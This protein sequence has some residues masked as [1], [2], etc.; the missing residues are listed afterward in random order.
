M[1]QE[2]SIGSDQR[3][4]AMIAKKL[5]VI[6]IFLFPPFTSAS[7]LCIL[8][9]Y[10]EKT[11][12]YADFLASMKE[13]QLDSKENKL[14]LLPS[15]SLSTGQYVSNDVKPE[16][17]EYS[18]V[19]LTISQEI[20]GGGKYAI[21]NRRLELNE[22]DIKLSVQESR[23]EY[24]MSLASDISQLNYLSDQLKLN[25]QRLKNQ[26]AYISGLTTKLKLGEVALIE[27][28]TAKSNYSQ[29]KKDKQYI[30][31]KIELLKWSISRGFKIPLDKISA[32]S[33]E[34]IGVC[35]KLSANDIIRKKAELQFHAEKTS[36]DIDKSSLSPSVTASLTFSPK[37]DSSVHNISL[38]RGEYGAYLGIS[39]PISDLFKR[40]ILQE[41]F[42]A[43]MEKLKA[44]SDENIYQLEKKKRDLETSISVAMDELAF[45]RDEVRLKKKQLEYI[46]LVKDKNVIYYYDELLQY[47]QLEVEIKK[48]EREL[49]Y[50][51]IQLYFIE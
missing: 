1:F 2:K 6:L 50:Y 12:E 40:G 37:G 13:N 34:Q 49:E 9:R 10:F 17:F 20:Y 51:N 19:G 16:P 39:M 31:K 46:N 5:F 22:E 29:Y 38:Q 47:Q 8:D 41:R 35:K 21:N 30:Q 4:N 3:T 23:N 33:L 28:D 25:E 27:L 44:S 32:T 36:Y 42:K 24:Y 7:E 26:S 15:I 45:M 48:K 14:S 18:N 11:T 43:R